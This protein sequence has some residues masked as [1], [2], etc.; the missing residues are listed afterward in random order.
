MNKVIKSTLVS[1]ALMV[2]VGTCAAGVFVLSAVAVG[3]AVHG[4]AVEQL[5][6]TPTPADDV[7]PPWPAPQ[8]VAVPVVEVGL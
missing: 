2:F 1:A 7:D 5:V 4:T 6:V 3:L 8:P